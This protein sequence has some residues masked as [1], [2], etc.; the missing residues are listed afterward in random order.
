LGY[1]RVYPAARSAQSHAGFL[2]PDAVYAPIIQ[3]IFA[4]YATGG[5]SYVRLVEWLN[6]DPRIP[7]PPRKTTWSCATI[8]DVLRNPVYC[9]LVRY[10][11]RPEGR[12]ER[13]SPG[14]EFVEPGRHVALIGHDLFDRVAERRA[15]TKTRADYR[16]HQPVL[17]TGL[18]VCTAC[19][20]PMTASHQGPNMLYRCSWLQRRKGT[21]PG[22]HGVGSYAGEL[23]HQALLREV[24][25]L[26]S[27]AWT[28][29]AERSLREGDAGT[30]RTSHDRLRA[31]HTQIAHRALAAEI[32]RYAGQGNTELLHNA[33][34]DLVLAARIVERLP[35]HQPKWLRAQVSWRPDVQILLDA[36]LLY[37][38]P[39]EPPPAQ[40]RHLER[41]RE[42]QR[43]YAARRRQGKSG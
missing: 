41:H 39:A 23:A 14:S 18:F 30:Q 19:G 28:L 11:H 29:E 27:A 2:V 12:Y 3:E 31:L 42:A 1:T 43:R 34:R 32:E 40:S 24:R 33:V 35:E 8:R 25:R 21:H 26:Q 10:N 17:G 4:R 36:G 16:R 13:A 15:A 9:G 37:L 38:E 22:V 5:W 7:P 6:A 20:G